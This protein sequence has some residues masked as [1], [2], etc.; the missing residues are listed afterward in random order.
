MPLVEKSS[1]IM[2]EIN[3]KN[4]DKWLKRMKTSSF[5]RKRPSTI[6]STGIMGTTLTV[7]GP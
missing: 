2:I 3:D 1:N 5:R 7:A 4:L 6:D